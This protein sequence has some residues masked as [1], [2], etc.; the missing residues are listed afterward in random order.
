MSDEKIGLIKKPLPISLE[1]QEGAMIIE[2]F[3]LN[4]TKL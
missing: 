3:N 2:S 1:T 4:F